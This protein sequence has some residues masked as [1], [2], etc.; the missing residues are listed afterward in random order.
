MSHTT[1]SS[2]PASRRVETSVIADGLEAYRQSITGIQVVTPATEREL[3]VRA[4]AGDVE[5][6]QALIS[7]NLKFV[8]K[9]AKEQVDRGC[10]LGMSE[11]ISEGNMGLFDALERYDMSQT[12]RFLTYADSWVKNR[13]EEAVSLM[14]GP[15]RVPQDRRIEMRKYA[16]ATA[17]LLTQFGR[18]PTDDEVAAYLGV[19]LA[20][21]RGIQQAPWMIYELDGDPTSSEDEGTSGVRTV[22]GGEHEMTPTADLTDVISDRLRDRALL[23]RLQLILDARELVVIVRYFGLDGRPPETLTQI[24]VQIPRVMTK[25][26]RA[27]GCFKRRAHLVRER[28]RG[29][30]NTALAKIAADPQVGRMAAEFLLAA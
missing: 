28:V 20:A 5:A 4:K 3:L 2:R 18:A 13:M 10:P 25:A 1:V 11:L 9:K 19:S 8:W 14:G 24:A 15:V 6:A 30:R 12:V 27:A 16:V 22:A 23:A 7:A 29:L 21:L 26:E 17:T